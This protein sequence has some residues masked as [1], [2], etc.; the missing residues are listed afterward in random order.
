MK[1]RKKRTVSSEQL[2]E[3]A[4]NECL[5]FVIFDWGEGFCT[6]PRFLNLSEDE[7]LQSENIAGFFTDMMFSYL[8]RVPQEW[9]ADAMRECCVHL[10]PEKMS[11]GP[12]FFR[13]VVPVLSAFF[14]YL[15]E[16]H[17]Q[18]NAAVMAREIK[19]LHERIMER[20]SNP[21]N[22]G[23]SKRFVMAAR[24]D[25]IDVMDSKAV[26]KYIEAYNQ[27][28]LRE[29]PASSMFYNAPHDSVIGPKGKKTTR[30]R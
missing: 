21:D 26:Q 14:A 15:D 18:K 24:S 5:D 20:S 12:E 6:S 11:E 16:H 23:M 2:S 7:R 19:T 29:G 27:K 13:C 1:Q 8:G 3:S 30:K 22:W 28:V 10:F 4:L 25:G 17:L 9:D